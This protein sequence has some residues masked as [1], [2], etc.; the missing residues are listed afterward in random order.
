MWI[1]ILM[2]L[3]E[4]ISFFPNK[5]SAEPDGFTIEFFKVL[6]SALII[7]CYTMYAESLNTELLVTLYIIQCQ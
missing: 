3:K 1:L 2:R 5:K 4:A 7:A 6:C